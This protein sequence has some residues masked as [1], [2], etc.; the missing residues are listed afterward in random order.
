MDRAASCN[1]IPVASSL[2]GRATCTSQKLKP[3]MQ[4]TT[5]VRW[6]TWWPTPRCSA[7][8]PLW[9][10]GETVSIQSS[11]PLPPGYLAHWTETVEARASL[12]DKSLVLSVTL[13]LFFAFAYK[14]F[15]SS[16]PASELCMCETLHVC[17][18][19]H[20]YIIRSVVCAD[21]TCTPA[22]ERSTQLA[23]H[24]KPHQS[25]LCAPL[26]I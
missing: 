18:N 1:R 21:K 7:L 14:V 17:M 9:W 15:F 22:H 5:R 19:T 10:C 13:F 25:H 8:Q 4:G 24:A 23:T 3:Q 2:R 26:E 16:T 6:E 11:P 20:I 12:G